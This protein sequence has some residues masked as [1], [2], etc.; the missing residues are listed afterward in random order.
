M[1]YFNNVAMMVFVLGSLTA[2]QPSTAE[3]ISPTE[4][5][6]PTPEPMIIPELPIEKPEDITDADLTNIYRIFLELEKIQ[7]FA[8]NNLPGS[9]KISPDGKYMLSENWDLDFYPKRSAPAGQTPTPS[10]YVLRDLKTQSEIKII[11]QH[12]AFPQEAVDWSP[13]NQYFATKG[14]E[15]LRFYSTQ[16][17]EQVFEA[18]LPDKAIEH[19]F[20]FNWDK[21]KMVLYT[22][23]KYWLGAWENER[24][25]FEYVSDFTGNCDTYHSWWM[26]NYPKFY[27]Y[28]LD[29]KSDTATLT[30]CNDLTGEHKLLL[31]W[32]SKYG[33]ELSRDI[34]YRNQRAHVLKNYDVNHL[35]IVFVELDLAYNFVPE[36]ELSP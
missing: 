12:L 15:G 17:G 33:L 13:D 28:N 11:L 9:H 19:S 1:K 20:T 5:Q 25:E 8:D 6:I 23:F 21:D 32:K 35:V 14:Y 31:E 22:D 3:P 18:E 10:Y 4:R 26:Y 29:G 24:V 7:E 16:N 27:E 2:C 36:A 34:E 30:L